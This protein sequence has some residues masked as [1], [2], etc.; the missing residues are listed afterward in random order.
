MTGCTWG[1]QSLDLQPGNTT[2]SVVV[3]E[4]AINEFDQEHEQGTD[5]I[6]TDNA[7]TDGMKVD[8]EADTEDMDGV[9]G[10]DWQ[11]DEVQEAGDKQNVETDSE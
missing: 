7:S 10:Q 6:Q 3:I 1:F 9:Q 11:L 4:D 5:E 2:I 8:V